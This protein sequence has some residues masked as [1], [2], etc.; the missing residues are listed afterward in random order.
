MGVGM[1][2]VHWVLCQQGEESASTQL[3]DAD[4]SFFKGTTS[5]NSTDYSNTGVCRFFSACTATMVGICLELCCLSY[6]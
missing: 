3:K 2:V 1:L 4:F 5:Y 6:I